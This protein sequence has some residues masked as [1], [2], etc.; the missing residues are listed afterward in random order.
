MQS[1]Y[2]YQY[3]DPISQEPLYIGKGT[4]DRLNDH[5]RLT[6][7]GKPT[8]NKHWTAKL[9][10]MMQA[11]LE[12]VI[13]ILESNLT[14]AEALIV[15]ERLIKQFGRRDYDKDG[16]LYNHL[17]KSTDWTGAHHSQETKD[18]IGRAHKGKKLAAWH[19]VAI[20]QANTGK[21]ISQEHKAA[22]SK[23]NSGPKTEAAKKAM[24]IAAK[25]KRSPAQQ[26]ALAKMQQ[27]HSL[28]SRRKQAEKL[29]GKPRSEETKAKMR[30]A[31][32]LRWS[33]RSTSS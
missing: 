26:E 8:T 24:S 20:K 27:N 29:K 4:G 11:G 19:V 14:A 9:A 18:K 31:A 13:E 3:L 1:F 5:W 15:E 10:L 2:V 25:A 30:E 7:K 17:I 22:I 32:L 33:T 6:L 23:A 28:E 16:I 21:L 12:P